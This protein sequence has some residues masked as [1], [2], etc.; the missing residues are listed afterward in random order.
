MAELQINTCSAMFHRCYKDNWCTDVHMVYTVL[1]LQR[2][3]RRCRCSI[4]QKPRS[5]TSS[6][7]Q[8][9]FDCYSPEWLCVLLIGRILCNHKHSIYIN[10]LRAPGDE[11]AQAEN[12]MVSKGNMSTASQLFCPVITVTFFE[13]IDWCHGL[14]TYWRRQDLGPS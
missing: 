12:L 10:I 2:A 5:V 4:N 6:L 13:N 3:G 7:K 8:T 9:E 11:E 14:S 1:S